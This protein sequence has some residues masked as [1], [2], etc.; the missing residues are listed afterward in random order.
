VVSLLH[1]RLLF[2]L[3]SSLCA[4]DMHNQPCLS[5]AAV[6]SV[7]CANVALHGSSALGTR[8]EARV[9]RVPTAV[10]NLREE[11]ASKVEIAP[12][13]A[14]HMFPGAIVI[15]E[16]SHDDEDLADWS[17]SDHHH[18]PESTRHGVL[19]ASVAPRRAPQ[20]ELERPPRV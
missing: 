14:R 20:S 2:G 19:V 8:H 13:H 16:V 6:G 12:P 11:R 7:E 17:V 4:G 18:F 15:D 3:L 9:R 5:A 10:L 1:I